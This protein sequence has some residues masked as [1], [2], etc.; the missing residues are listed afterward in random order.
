MF[1]EELEM[2]IDAAIADGVITEKE[3]LIL[4]KRAQAEGVD[5]DEL[6]MIIDARLAKA[7]KSP[8]QPQAEMSKPQSTPASIPPRDPNKP[9]PVKMLM[10]SLQQ[11]ADSYSSD[12]DSLSS[13]KLY[14]VK[15]EEKQRKNRMDI[16][17]DID[18][19][20]SRRDEEIVGAIQN[21]II[22]EH[23]D[24]MFEL[25]IVLKPYLDETYHSS[26]GYRAEKAFREKYKA[27]VLKAE[28]Y[29]DAHPQLQRLLDQQRAAD[30][31]EQR[32]EE[33]RKEEE[34]RQTAT[35]LK[36]LVDDIKKYDFKDGIISTREVKYAKAVAAVIE[37]FLLPTDRS[38]LLGLIEMLYPYSN[39]NYWQTGETEKEIIGKA[40]MKKYEAVREKVMEL[41]PDDPAFTKFFPKK[42]G[43]FEGLFGS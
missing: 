37:M 2:L 40:Y 7:Q 16:D 27:C 13:K 23:P 9:S 22:P 4:H 14:W 19:L 17:R 29:Y 41:F 10:N 25:L 6:D 38:D 1:S 11:I 35:K 20:E 15:D 30:L 28:R 39:K 31:E 36:K 18:D 26:Y 21:F 24:D 34:K 43:W 32:E 33:K 8:A 12:I 3:R 42:K 5:V